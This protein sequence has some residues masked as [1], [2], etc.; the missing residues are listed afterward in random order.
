MIIA[1]CSDTGAPVAAPPVPGPVQL[2]A[3]PPP[4]ALVL[5]V[6]ATGFANLRALHV[7]LAA[8][9]AG[10]D[11]A[12]PIELLL[13]RAAILG[14]VV[15]LVEARDR[16]EHWLATA[17]RD[18]RAWR[19]R[20][21]VLLALHR[22]AE[23]GTALVQARATGAEVEDLA[24]TLA[25]LTGDHARVATYRATV[26]RDQP[27]TAHLLAWAHNLAL[28]GD[29]DAALAAMPRALA[30]DPA[31]A[32]PALAAVLVRWGELHVQRGEPA[33]ARRMFA[34]AVARMPAQVDAGALLADALR[35]TGT[36]AAPLLARALADAS[37]GAEP[38]HP[39]LLARAGR[40][41]EAAAAWAVRLAALPELSAAPAARFFLE[42][43]GDPARALALARGALAG[44]GA[45]SERELVIEAALA[46]GQPA[47]A[48]DA[49]RSLREGT[50]AQRFLA[51]R[52]YGACDRPAEA[53]A[54]ARSL[55]IPAR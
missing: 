26:A 51:W 30:A 39:E 40:T 49:A 48:C 18:P 37:A 34:E 36:D 6:T 4:D 3:G 38:L 45:S 1:G 53:A 5:P 24:A 44:C 7:E 42:L 19:A 20:V 35:A 28:A 54:A 11:R 2:A 9:R 50:R 22:C 13:Q 12:R 10:D 14:H 32:G 29:T 46:A 23:A 43:G 52:A 17:P 27:T 8:A 47:I 33:A 16:S 25:E 21:T 41:T 31:L 15:D 55:G